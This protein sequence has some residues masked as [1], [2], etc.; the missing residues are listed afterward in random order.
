[1]RYHALVALRAMA[2]GVPLPHERAGTLL[3]FS[4][5][6]RMAIDPGVDTSTLTNAQLGELL[7]RACIG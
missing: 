2:R 7:A 3:S 6:D 4:S 1:M 5:V